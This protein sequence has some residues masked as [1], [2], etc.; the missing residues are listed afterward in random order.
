MRMRQE[1]TSYKEEDDENEQEDDENED[2]E[3]EATSYKKEHEDAG[4]GRGA[5]RRILRTTLR[6]KL[7][8]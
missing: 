3:N 2:D 6:D 8:S 5:P 7:L 1:G 4:L